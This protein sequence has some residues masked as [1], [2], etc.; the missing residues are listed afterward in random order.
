MSLT[1]YQASAGSGKTYKL[2]EEYLLL[3]FKKPASYKNILAVTFTNKATAEMKQRILSELSKLAGNKTSPYLEVLCKRF[4]VGPEQIR[5]QAYHILHHLLHDY[6]KFTVETIDRFFQRIL[7]SF[8]REIH[9]QG[10][11]SIELDQ[12]RVLR[13]AI[14]NL[15]LSA[16]ESPQLRKWLIDFAN[17]RVKA[18]KSWDLKSAVYQLSKEIF[19]EKFQL[20]GNSVMQ[21]IN[22][23]DFLK[24]YVSSLYAIKNGFE[25]TMR[26]FGTKAL[27]VMKSYQLDVDDFSYKQSGVAG[28]FVRLAEKEDVEPKDRARKAAGNPE[29]WYSKSSNRKEE[30]SGAVSNGLNHLLEGAINHYD[31]HHLHYFTADAIL[32]NMYTLG[33]IT[34]IKQQVRERCQDENIFLL[35]D[36][37]TFISRIISGTDAPFL[38]EKV[39]NHFHH[40][41]LDEFQ[42]TSQVQWDNF[43]PLITN[44]LALGYKNIVVG[45]VKQSIYRWRNSSWKILAQ[46][47]YETMAPFNPVNIGLENNWR[48][49]PEVVKFNNTIFQLAPDYLQEL[50]NLEL[51]QVDD[52]SS[53]FG[54]MIR[55]AYDNT[56]QQVS[57]EL[58]GLVEMKFYQDNGD[59]D[60]WKDQALMA[61]PERID[62]LKRRGL[63][64]SDIAILVRNQKE[65][66]LIADYLMD[67]NKAVPKNEIP[68][69]SNDALKLEVSV[70][71]KIMVRA[72]R[73]LLDPNDV[74]NLY[75]LTYHYVTVI[76]RE[77]G[78]EFHR[79]SRD[80][81]HNL[82]PDGFVNRAGEWLHL[83]LV[84]IFEE[85]VQCLGLN[86]S[87][88]EQ[89]YLYA[90][91]DLIRYYAASNNP[92]LAAFLDWW[93][94]NG[95][96]QLLKVTG[97]QDA[98]SI[99]T[100]HKSKGLEFN[101]VF[102]PFCDWDVDHNPTLDNIL[103]C[104]TDVPPFNQLEL[105]PV[106]YASGLAK[107]H[108]KN[109]YYEEKMQ[110][111]VDS[112]NLLYVAFTRARQFLFVSMPD[113]D[114]VKRKNKT[115]ARML[116]DILSPEYQPEKNNL[117]IA[118]TEYWDKEGLTFQFGQQ[119]HKE[120]ATF[121]REDEV[122]AM[123]PSHS[124]KVKYNIS[125]RTAD[126]LK[127]EGAGP[128]LSVI[129]E[130]KMM[131]RIFENI[132]SGE[133]IDKAIDIVMAEGIVSGSEM[134]HIKQKIYQWLQKPEVSG[135][136]KKG[137][138]VKTEA[139]VLLTDGNLR[140]PDRVIFSDDGVQVVDFKFGSKQRSSDV[141]QMKYY[142]K[143]LQSMGYRDIDG[144]IWYA[145]LGSVK[146]VEKGS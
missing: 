131:H 130:G 94:K 44:S 128:E 2:T 125:Y 70:L 3:L 82:L 119:P 46:D 4:H 135:W 124:P 25:S 26:S 115:I 133:D 75:E 109:D 112:L 12:E 141:D 42:D 41:M 51:Q 116:Y 137:I 101:A 142:M 89:A 90:F 22:D 145:E 143:L 99:V 61:L 23:K 144:Y 81:L 58:K 105:L 93:D 87:T 114:Q 6:S 85:T 13:D 106:R 48:S 83:P 29:K 68:F 14:D 18:G 50:Y 96:Q 64:H 33:I 76:K 97:E 19:N 67:Y 28:Y 69:I 104:H 20:L 113:P 15:L 121:A 9:V 123:F 66:I 38:F 40:Y 62:E 122:L 84:H 111:Y 120:V 65:G 103:W 32:K 7:R 129:D 110:S 88:D 102:I 77:P 98:I 126:W 60:K 72:F 39:G 10:T 34:D 136:F 21:K 95:D 117:S 55:Q 24:K 134:V 56:I 16:G 91:A 53:E 30:I 47:I 78:F 54:E 63:M 31:A 35:S 71:V 43:K 108:F 127:E 1:I 57:K 107:T 118:L 139:S 74:L 132:I 138:N 59:G 11:F 52:V 80:S 27:S 45:D 37:G 100:I 17:D 73:Y 79:Y 92:G 49:A 146:K 86:K 36:A 8:I 140:R 5:S